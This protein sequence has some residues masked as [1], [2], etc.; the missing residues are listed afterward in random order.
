MGQAKYINIAMMPLRKNIPTTS[1]EDW[2]ITT[3]PECGRECWRMGK[4]ADLVE[5][6]CPGTRFLCT[7][8]ALSFKQAAAEN[9]RTER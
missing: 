6:M 4:N 8:C 7:E 5:S 9:Q 3:C 1:N 2:Q